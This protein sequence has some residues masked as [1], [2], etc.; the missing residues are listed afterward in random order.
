MPGQTVVGGRA[1]WG[2]TMRRALEGSGMARHGQRG[3][4]KKRWGETS[5]GGKLK[6]KKGA[7]GGRDV[8]LQRRKV[9]G[10]SSSL[11][12]ASSLPSSRR[13][14]LREP[15]VALAC[16]AAAGAFS[17]LKEERE[18]ES[19]R[20]S[21]RRAR[22]AWSSRSRAALSCARSPLLQ[23]GLEPASGIIWL[24]PSFFL[25]LLSSLPPIRPP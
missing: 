21:Q 16:A 9:S 8:R 12:A 25:I 3:R 4:R 10:R 6:G 19:N 23:P 22:S 15:R 7:E 2:R 13:G 11:C 18:K 5:P 20:K 17:V 24:K 14:W 1:S